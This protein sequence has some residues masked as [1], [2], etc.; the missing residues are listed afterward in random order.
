MQLNANTGIT[1][2][3]DIECI[4]FTHEKNITLYILLEHEQHLMVLPVIGCISGM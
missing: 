4:I 2:C 1:V 3:H